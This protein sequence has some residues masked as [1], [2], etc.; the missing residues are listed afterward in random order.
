MENMEGTSN[1]SATEFEQHVRDALDIQGR[2]FHE[3]FEQLQARMQA[4]EVELA[5]ARLAGQ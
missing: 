2:Q 4:T 3:V 5:S 1:M